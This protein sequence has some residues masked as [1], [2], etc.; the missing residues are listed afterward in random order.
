M[1]CGPEQMLKDF[2]AEKAQIRNTINIKNK[3][4]LQKSQKISNKGGE[5]I[6]EKELG[7]NRLISRRAK[8]AERR[9]VI[10]IP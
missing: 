3:D 2:P 4:D 7:V 10:N 9:D 5:I 8:D 6:I 1:F